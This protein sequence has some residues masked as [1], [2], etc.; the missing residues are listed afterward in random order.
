[1]IERI[2]INLLPAEYRIHA[3]RFFLQREI[4]YPILFIV[5]LFITLAS[6]AYSYDLRISE[7][8]NRIQEV[9]FKIKKNQHIPKEIKKLQKQQDLIQ[10][11][12]KALELIDV[13]REK[14]I[15]LQEVFCKTLP[16]FTWLEKIEEK[17]GQSK[18]IEIEG[19]TFSLSE[20]ASYMSL[21]LQSDFVNEIDLKRIEQAN[22][23][24]DSNQLLYSFVFVCSLNS[25]IKEDDL[26]KT[27]EKS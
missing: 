7:Y 17:K 8:N 4:V 13:N 11:K 20:V 1:M 23:G 6:F 19:K 25:S 2:E 14:W 27:I 12:I 18:L 16:N 26:T 9:D 3:K 10:N 24:T 21:L 22:S 5:S 15:R